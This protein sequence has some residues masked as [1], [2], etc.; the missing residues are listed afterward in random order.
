M[1]QPEFSAADLLRD[2]RA[3]E[4]ADT[5]TRIDKAL[6]PLIAEAARVINREIGL[7]GTF[8]PE[9]IAEALSDLID[10]AAG[11]C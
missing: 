3:E 10:R 5:A 7:R 11:N 6:E 4:A 1:P 9:D 2:R 8:T